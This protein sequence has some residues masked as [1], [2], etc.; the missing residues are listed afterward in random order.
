MIL[1]YKGKLKLYYD[2]LKLRYIDPY[3]Y[4]SL[5]RLVCITFVQPT[6]QPTIHL[7]STKFK[8]PKFDSETSV[9]YPCDH[10]NMFVDTRASKMDQ[11]YWTATR[12]LG[13]AIKFIPF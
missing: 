7:L 2:S 1:L 5:Y 10:F 12:F 3:V 8:G 6:G 11:F 13:G 9:I 4:D